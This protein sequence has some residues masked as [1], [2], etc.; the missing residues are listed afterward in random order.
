VPGVAAILDPLGFGRHTFLCGQSGSGKTYS[1]GVLL[2]RLLLRTR[3]PIVIL[4]P[5]S[6]HVRLADT[7]A[8]DP[9]PWAAVAEG[10]RVRRYGAD[11]DERLRVRLGQLDPATQAALL[12]LD[13][14]T[15]REEYAAYL[16]ALERHAATDRKLSAAELLDGDD[17]GVRA[18]RLRFGNLGIGAWQIWARSTPGPT[19]L[20]ELGG[21]AFRA[22]C[23][24]LGTVPS[25]DE[26]AVVATAVVERLWEDRSQRRPVL[27][28]IDEAHNVCPAQPVDP[29][30]ARA[31]ETVV[32][33]AAEGRKYGIYLLVSTQRPEKVHPEVLAQ[34]DSLVCM[35]M[36]SPGAAADLARSFGFAPASLL[37]QAP[38]FGLGEALVAGRLAPHPL[39]VRFGER[40]TEEGGADVP[41]DW[42]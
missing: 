23:V 18:L 15:E 33:I 6:D 13:P 3:L 29:L 4:D 31:T 28:V 42:L 19:L 7:R 2:E 36:N 26:R 24:D 16:D 21:R 1:L 39:L 37:E 25:P 41:A 34:C 10:I 27:V 30:T 40:L 8:A 9:G 12:R 11:G 5:N 20:D 35:R 38:A 32:R 22:L 17:P 14:I